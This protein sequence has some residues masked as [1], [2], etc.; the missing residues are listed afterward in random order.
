MGVYLESSIFLALLIPIWAAVR[1]KAFRSARTGSSFSFKREIILNVFFIYI[2]CLINVTLF[3]LE[4]SFDR[5]YLWISVNLIPLVGTIREIVKTT[6]DPNMPSYMIGFWIKNI[7]GNVILLLPFGIMVPMLWSKFKSAV[8]TTLC[9][10]CISL[11]IE[12][13]QLLSCFVGNIGRAFD[14]D[15]ILLNTI[16]A[17]IGYIIY[18]KFI[19]NRKY[20]LNKHLK[21]DIAS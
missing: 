12:V 11:S 10:F 5:D 13:L 14:V 17:F 2:L 19:E 16:G 20:I 3:P 18:K 4:I 6:N 7:V 8:K 21:R 1:V 15:D 9:A